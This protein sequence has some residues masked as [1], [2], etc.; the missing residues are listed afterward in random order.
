MA[1]TEPAMQ[2]NNIIKDVKNYNSTTVSVRTLNEKIKK[3]QTLQDYIET[4]NDF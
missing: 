1:V 2:Q 4:I 3:L